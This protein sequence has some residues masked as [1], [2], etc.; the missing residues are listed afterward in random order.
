[1][2]KPSTVRDA[3]P[4]SVLLITLEII[5]LHCGNEFWIKALRLW[6]LSSTTQEDSFTQLF[7][8][9][10]KI[11]VAGNFIMKIVGSDAYHRLMLQVKG[12]LSQDIFSIIFFP[13]HQLLK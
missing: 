9:S 6:I 1:M 11:I 12:E 8:P 10:C 2:F 3:L 7:V 5:T 13:S 4:S